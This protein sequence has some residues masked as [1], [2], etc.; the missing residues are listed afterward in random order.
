MRASK[1]KTIATDVM[2][3]QAMGSAVGQPHDLRT[4][5]GEMVPNGR[6]AITTSIFSKRIPFLLL[7]ILLYLQLGA[8][9]PV[10]DGSSATRAGMLYYDHETATD[11]RDR[12]Y[13]YTICPDSAGCISLDFNLVECL[14]PGEEQDD[15]ITVYD[16]ASIGA[17][18]LGTLGKRSGSRILQGQQACITVVF[19][20]DVLSRNSIWTAL[21]QTK[22]K[23]TC[24]SPQKQG[25]CADV[26][27]ICG[28]SYHENFLYYGVA[29]P[30]ALETVP[31]SCVERPHNATW[32]RFMA[33]KDGLLSFDILPD[34]GLDD[35]DWVLLQGNPKDPSAC[36]DLMGTERK[37]ACNYA[38]GCGPQGAT[39]MGERGDAH[40]AAASDSPY[41][42]GVP[43]RKG[44]VF[45]LLIDDFS[46]HS[47]GFHIR[48][49]DV[50]MACD[51][52]HKDLLKIDHQ[53]SLGRAPV[54]PRRA[55]TQYTRILRIDLG[56]KANASLAK[57]TL[58]SDLFAHQTQASGKS[59]GVLDQLPRCQGIAQLLL[60]GLKH[61]AL[62]AFAAHDFQTPL[63]Y[64]DLLEVV[65]RQARDT[66][67]AHSMSWWN[68]SEAALER[69]TQVVEIIVDERFDKT[70]GTASQQIRYLRLLWTDR[71]S[72]APDYNVAVFKY[73]DV[74][75]LLDKVY[76]QSR[77]NDVPTISLRDALEGRQYESL[78]VARTGKGMKNLGQARFEGERQ[79]EL[80][81]FVWPR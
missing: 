32:Y 31:G 56:E 75:P 11:Q 54:D 72:Q 23:A 28:P 79:L 3:V 55:F 39:G 78:M 19:K 13:I 63:H 22:S 48:F 49:N 53:V 21:W 34:N 76:C 66:S 58:P 65:A 33:Q 12:I 29:A 16:G 50:V 43:A 59:L 47:S 71:D 52:P 26:H 8:Q 67:I 18:L 42:L 14:Q 45:F 7:G 1:A 46:Q 73:E 69:Y 27:D 38:I 10:I 24:I 64:G 51:N 17:P 37:L 25:P 74:R 15:F 80:E 61:G 40:S 35:F 41:S 20:R 68:P 30:Q 6:K 36:P 2:H 5:C 9:L 77:H 60:Q 70:L 57:A 62:P 81:N 4:A 44:D